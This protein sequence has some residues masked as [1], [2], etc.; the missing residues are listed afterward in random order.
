[1]GIPVLIV[2]ESGSGKSASMRNCQAGE[3]GI[4]N[5]AGKRFPF[6]NKNGL[7]KVDNATY[8]EVF[9][10]LSGKHLNSYIIDD[11]QYLMS[12][13]MFNRAGERGYDKFTDIAVHF[14]KMIDYVVR[15][16][17]D[18]IIVYLFHH[19]ERSDTNKLKAKTVGKMLDNQ[20]T[21]EGL[22]SIVLYCEN[23][24]NNYKFI[25]QGNGLT[26]AKSPMEMFDMEIDN[27]IV[28]VDDI[29][30]EYYE[31]KARTDNKANAEKNKNKEI[32]G[33]SK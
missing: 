5:V 9:R 15:E 28:I 13:E 30:R 8:E 22:F 1:M 32:K 14:K 4:L 20:L 27:D 19:V 10:I 6:K 18:D 26:T 12:F 3:F 2:G 17:P 29:I 11:S 31:L 25:T 7:K 16:M 33:E 23:V 21:L 24:D